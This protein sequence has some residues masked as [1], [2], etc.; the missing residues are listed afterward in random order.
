MTF[1]PSLQPGAFGERRPVSADE[2]LRLRRT[3]WADGSVSPDE[4]AQ[5]FAM[6]RS[7][8][9][10]NDWTD[11]FVEALC[12]YVI[13][14]GEPR[15][16]VTEPDAEWLIGHIG[17]NGRIESHAELELVVKLF[18]RADSV[19]AR[20]KQFAL[21]EI[22]QTVMTGAG[23]TRG[24]GDIAPGRIDQAEVRLLRRLI[25]SPASD[26]PG[27][28][29]RAEADL[30]FRLKDKTLNADNAPDWPRLF[31][32]GVAN[33]LMAHRSSPLTEREIG[34]RAESRQAGL[35][36]RAGELWSGIVRNPAAIGA[37]L[38]GE[39]EQDRIAA[40]EREV[41]RDSA[42]TPEESEWLKR[43]F[44]ADGAR[45]PLE[46]ALLD[47]LAEDGARPF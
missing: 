16:C 40:H 38:F 32:Q 35:G 33:H 17:S 30:L 23:P 29:S 5:L 28:V 45:D 4:A 20:L 15:G 2:V 44:D 34:I 42:V 7:A 24:G 47:F 11:F 6:N 46:Q 3:V 26:G 22:E 9:P 21:G 37:E 39:S 1:D 31:V 12:D 14:R 36:A 41:A 8:E 10:S 27:R 18:E 25:F 13:G 19:P 43:L